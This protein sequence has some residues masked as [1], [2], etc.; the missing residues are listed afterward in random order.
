MCNRRPHAKGKGCLLRH[1]KWHTTAFVGITDEKR[2]DGITTQHWLSLVDEAKL[3]AW[4]GHS[5]NASHFK[6]GLMMH[7]WSGLMSR[8][9]F[10]KAVWIEFGCPGHGKGPWDG[11]GAVI[12]QRVSRDMTNG[13]IRTA[14][15]N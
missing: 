11:M 3:W 4:L 6:S 12:K 8:I 1:S 10:L 7:Y 5:D 15:G 2:H 14:S 13:Q 9:D